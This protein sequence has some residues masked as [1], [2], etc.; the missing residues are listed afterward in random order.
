M[1]YK[2][3][4][5]KVSRATMKKPCVSVVI[6]SRSHINVEQVLENTDSSAETD[7]SSGSSE[8]NLVLLEYV[9]LNI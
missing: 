1:M 5:I 3:K 7:F 2:L 4:E 9:L 8:F 6:L